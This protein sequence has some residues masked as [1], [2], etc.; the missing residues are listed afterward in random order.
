MLYKSVP[1]LRELK[2]MVLSPGGL[3]YAVTSR[4]R[5]IVR[6]KGE[7]ST[8]TVW[9]KPV[10]SKAVGSPREARFQN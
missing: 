1:T 4:L 10:V 6:L 7:Q 9:Q 2:V 5:L 8:L 3:V